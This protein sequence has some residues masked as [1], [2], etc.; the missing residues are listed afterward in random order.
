MSTIQ[1]VE[2]GDETVYV[3]ERDGM[4]AVCAY[5]PQP[6]EA[7]CPEARRIRTN[8]GGSPASSFITVTG[9]EQPRPRRHRRPG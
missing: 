5:W 8:Y 4:P 9:G 6:L 2:T 7:M 3:L 1:A